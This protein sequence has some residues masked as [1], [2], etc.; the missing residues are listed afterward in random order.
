MDAINCNI[1]I[2][3][4]FRMTKIRL[5]ASEEIAGDSFHLSL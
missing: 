2:F 3:N 1:M 4:Q 5:A